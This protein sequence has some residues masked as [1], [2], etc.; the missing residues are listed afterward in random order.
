KAGRAMGVRVVDAVA[1]G[2]S[3]FGG[4]AGESS[5]AAPSRV[6][7]AFLPPAATPRWEQHGVNDEKQICDGTP[8]RPE[9]S[10]RRASLSGTAG[11]NS[12]KF[13]APRQFRPFRAGGSAN[14]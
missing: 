11:L 10:G 6:A 12:G 3:C 4:S 5:K 7:M 14:L 1:A 9:S 13:A 2:R 8:D